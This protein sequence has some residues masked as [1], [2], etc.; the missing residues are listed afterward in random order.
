LKLQVNRWRCRNRCC[1][2]RFFTRS[3]VGVV[4]AYARET[5]R[6]RDLTLLIGHALGG[7]PGQRLMSRF[8]M[9]TSDDTILRRL[10]HLPRESV[11]SEVRVMGV[12]E[13]AWSRGQTFGTILVDL[14]SGRVVDVLAESS[15]DALAAWLTAHPGVTTISRDRHGRYAEGARRAVPHAVQVADRFHLVRNLR[16]AVERELALHRRDLRVSLPSQTVP[17]AKPQGEKNTKQIRVCSQVVEHRQEGVEQWRQEKL[18]LFETIQQMKA[19]GMKVSEIAGYLGIN[20]R[21]ID[22]W[23]RLEEFPERS[24]MDPRP[25]MVE[26]FREYLRERWEQGCHHGRELLAEIQQRGYIGCYTRLAELLSPWRQPKP[27]L[28]AASP[29]P[30]PISQ[31]QAVSQ[32]SARQISPQVAAALLNK[33]RPDLTARQAEI[34]DALKEQC[35]GYAVMRKLTF[36]FRAILLRGKVTTLHGWL[37]EA[38]RTGIHAMERFVRT[39]KQDL[40]AVESAVTERWSN[41]PVEGQINRLKALKRQ[42]YGRAGVELLRARV[43]PLPVV[44]IR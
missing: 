16:Q 3:L 41:G 25:G 30:P 2:V 33:P 38:Q 20:R 10:K 8:N 23:V 21:R 19:A 32:P 4:E 9:A 5:N 37:E 12:D 13:W 14:E 27:E 43:L 36:G 29:I 39:V 40:K 7:L 31:V 11:S 6:A 18:Q 28:E 42:M 26:S 22:K 35:P 1:S 44:E 17:A 15:A 24:R 34:V